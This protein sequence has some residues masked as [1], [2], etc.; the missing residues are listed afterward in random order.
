MTTKAVHELTPGFAQFTVSA[1]PT[2][3]DT[4]CEAMADG[5]EPRPFKPGPPIYEG[6][7]LLCQSDTKSG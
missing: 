1:H 7:R 6:R 2:G 4:L 3:V 5:Q